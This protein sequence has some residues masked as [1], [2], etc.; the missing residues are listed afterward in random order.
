MTENLLRLE[1]FISPTI[2]VIIKSKIEVITNKIYPR[3]TIFKNILISE[4]LSPDIQ[5]TLME[6]PIDINKPIIDLIPKYKNIVT[7]IE[8]IIEANILDLDQNNLNQ[9]EFRFFK[10]LCPFEKPFRILSFS[11]QDNNISIKKFPYQTL[12]I[13]GLDNFSCSKS[14][15]CN[16]P[17]D[18]YIS[19]GRKGVDDLGESKNFFKINNAKITIEKLEDL[20]WEKECHSMIY[21]PKNIYIS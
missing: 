20:P 9:K 15:Y 21:I 13:F 16:T 18:L 5:Y 12:N 10:I 7:E 1:D 2:R 19:G 4:N 3:R 17:Y 11:P 14:S 6:N 8:L